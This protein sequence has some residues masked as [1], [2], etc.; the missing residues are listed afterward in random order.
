MS[1][2]DRFL[3]AACALAPWACVSPP[4]L[5]DPPPLV[6]DE[7][8]PAL[9]PASAEWIEVSA[10]DGTHLRG[11][12]V[13]ADPGAPV[14]LALLEAQSS[15]AEHPR[16]YRELVERLGDAGFATLACDW[17]GVGISGGS[18]SADHLGEDA[19]ALFAEAVRRAG[20]DASRVAVRGVSLGTL[21]LAELLASGA[22]PGAALYVAPV[23]NATFAERQAGEMFGGAAGGVARLSFRRVPGVDP[24][25]ALA[26]STVPTLVILLKDES[27]L[28][29]AERAELRDAV[30][31]RDNVRLLEPELVPGALILGERGLLEEEQA[32]LARTFPK[33][34]HLPKRRERALL[35]L[36]PE[37]LAQL[38][39]QSLERA[40]FEALAMAQ[41]HTDPAWLAAAALSGS[42]PEYAEVFAR[43]RSKP[44]A[45]KGLAFDDLEH[46]LDFGDPSG[47]L[48]AKLLG[49]WTRTLPLDEDAYGGGFEGALAGVAD[50]VRAR[51]VSPELERGFE[52]QAWS[53]RDKRRFRVLRDYAPVWAALAKDVGEADAARRFTR[54]LLKAWG[55]AAD[56]VAAGPDGTPRV[57]VLADGRWIPFDEA[58][59]R[60]AAAY[61]ER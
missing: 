17:R 18:R 33:R 41:I 53:T 6:R 54:F 40:R 38:P 27:Y 21:A 43:A 19:A 24:A 48:P 11:V 32:W 10:R 28:S 30:A 14:V 44:G 25:E 47:R 60:D 59:R 13:P 42:G 58:A 16:G 31:G 36:A 35:A 37:A 29:D 34:F 9:Y 12:F 8:R 26:Q 55:L 20:G 7:R 52:F 15:V 23:R 61:A 49:S 50:V 56:R 39:P 46:A 1:R 4:V 2:A 51:G 5:R 3:A 45:W 22:A 57:E